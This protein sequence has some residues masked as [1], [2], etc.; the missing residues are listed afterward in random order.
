MGDTYERELKAILTGNEKALSKMTKTC[1]EEETEDYLSIGRR[2]FMVV[3][4]AGSLGID[5]VAL[6]GNLAFPIEVKSLKGDVLWFSNSQRLVE[7]GEIFMEECRRTGLIPIYAFRKKGVKGDP[8]RVFV[9]PTDNVEG[10]LGLVQRRLP[11]PE[12]SGKGYF[13]MRWGEGMKLSKLLAY[14]VDISSP[15]EGE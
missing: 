8:W 3:R 11:T 10:R 15:L 14:L 12:K 6:W 4:A 7:Q 9:L 13:I 5:L 2:P 1:N